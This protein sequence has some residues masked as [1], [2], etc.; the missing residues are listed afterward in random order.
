M[1][2]EAVSATVPLSTGARMA[3]LNHIAEIRGRFAGQV[4][5]DQAGKLNDVLAEYIRLRLTR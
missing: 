1:A 2:I 5:I 3:G 4:D